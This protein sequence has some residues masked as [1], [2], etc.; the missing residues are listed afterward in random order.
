MDLKTLKDI[1]ISFY[2]NNG[3]NTFMSN[4]NVPCMNPLCQLTSKQLNQLLQ[5]DGQKNP[6]EYKQ[7]NSSTGLAVNYY[8]LVEEIGTIRS[9]MFEDKV[10]VP[11]K[12]RGGRKANLD[13]SYIKDNILYYIESK[14]LEPYYSGNEV[15]KKSYF[16]ISRY[17]VPEEHKE[18][19]KKLFEDAQT[20]EIYN[21]SQL[22]R[23]LLAIWRKHSGDSNLKIV[24]QSI[25][26][27]MPDSF[28]NLMSNCSLQEDS[29]IRREK[30]EEE[31]CSCQKRINTF[32]A[33]ID[34]K[35]I[36][37]ECLHYNDRLEDIS[38]SG[39]YYEFKK[40]YFLE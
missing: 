16:D 12:G 6:D 5:G 24:L 26:W 29:I 36:S 27:Y 37:F 8:K 10:A 21:F 15:N 20:Y 38:T 33:N 35:N 31:A 4:N 22:C 30:I 17:D 23:H 19:W 9:L 25:T 28:I 2:S 11:L 3:I 14:Y 39:Q 7:I 1:I 13:V 18:E 40:R 34:W 32:L